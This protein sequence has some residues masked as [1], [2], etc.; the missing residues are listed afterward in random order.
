ME[1]SFGVNKGIEQTRRIRFGA[2]DV[3]TACPFLVAGVF[4]DRRSSFPKIYRIDYK[5]EN[6][7]ERDVSPCHV[8]WFRLCELENFPVR[9]WCES[10]AANRDRFYVRDFSNEFKNVS[11]SVFAAW[12]LGHSCYGCRIESQL[13]LSKK[14]KPSGWSGTSENHPATYDS[15][16]ELPR[17]DESAPFHGVLSSRLLKEAD[18]NLSNFP[19]PLHGKS[20]DDL[21]FAYNWLRMK[22]RTSY[23][24][25]RCLVA[26]FE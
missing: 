1:S 7:T 8:N 26:D 21:G 19:S 17:Y 5:N 24:S 22:Y 13:K 23:R 12:Q 16:N 25:R 14:A 10:A 4:T 6:E 18:R 2:A 11:V 3:V 15:S 9:R 20:K